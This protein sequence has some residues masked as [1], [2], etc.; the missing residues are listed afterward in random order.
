MPPRKGR[1]E[2]DQFTELLRLLDCLNRET[3]SA[4]MTNR[5]TATGNGT[6]LCRAR[7]DDLRELVGLLRAYYQF[8]GIRFDP[9]S[10]TAAL[11]NLLRRPSLGRVWIARD[12]G[13]AVGYA[14]LTF[15]YDVEFDGIQ[16]IVTDLFVKT[17][18]RGRRIGQRIIAA[19][20]EYCRVRKI[21]A[22]ELQVE[23]H[24]R[25]AQAFYRKV[26]FVRLSRIVMS[27]EVGKE[28]LSANRRRAAL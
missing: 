19:I 26:G 16:G 12:S 14:I 23:E 27:R 10:A 24:N 3:D 11:K 25:A 17:N 21:G 2:R 13:K 9:K 4:P 8:D 22:I 1:P 15:N 28:D 5:R 6:V 7:P 18:Y 20:E